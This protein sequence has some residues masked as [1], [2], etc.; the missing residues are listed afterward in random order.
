MFPVDF[1]FSFIYCYLLLLFSTLLLLK[2]LNLVNPVFLVVFF[3][4]VVVKLF[5]S[6]ASDFWFIFWSFVDN[7]DLYCNC[8]DF[9]LR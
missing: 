1:D 7:K 9:C 2:Y 4:V 5:P 3:V 6:T 8:W